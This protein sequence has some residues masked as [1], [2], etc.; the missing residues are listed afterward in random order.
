M[1]S[2]RPPPSAGVSTN[3]K[4]SEAATKP[5]MNLGNRRQISPAPGRGPPASASTRVTQN[6]ATRKATRPI[7]LFWIIFTMAAICSA[8]LPSR[9]PAATTAPVA[10]TVPPIQAAPTT[11]SMPTARMPSGISTI[12]RT[13]KISDMPTA[14]VSSSLCARA[15][16]ATAMAAETPHT[17]VAA[18]MTITSERLVIFSTRVPN[19]YMKTSTVGV[20]TQATNSPGAPSRSTLPNSTSAPSS[21]SPVLMYSSLRSAGLIQAGVP[22]VLAISSPPASA[23]K[24]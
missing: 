13:V 18:A 16:A 12:I 17:D 22:T 7:R 5:R 8:W 9:A 20:T 14:R 2:T 6:T 10:S 11:M 1:A 4:T 24:A 3:E 23:Q 21:T 19:R 15:A